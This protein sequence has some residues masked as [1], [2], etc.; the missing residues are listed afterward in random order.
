MRRSGRGGGRWLLTPRLV[1]EMTWEDRVWLPRRIKDLYK[2]LP[3]AARA[4]RAYAKHRQALGDLETYCMFI[5]YPRS[6]HSLIGSLLS[7]HP[8]MVIAHELDALHYLDFHFDRSLLFGAILARDEEFGSAHGR[9]WTGYSY[10]VEGQWQGRYRKLRVIG[11]KKGGD[12]STVLEGNQWQLDRLQAVTGLPLKVI[13]ITRN[14]YDNIATIARKHELTMDE[15]IAYYGR[16]ARS[17][18]ETT[19][20]LPPGSVLDMRLEDIV[21]DPKARIGELCAFLGVD[22]EDDYLEACAARVFPSPKKSRDAAGW[23]DATRA[24]VEALCAAVPALQ[25]YRFDD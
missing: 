22:A 18:M 12:S 13:H 6:G 21:D 11:D 19:A 10:A 4:A 7:A 5:G 8:D 25:G 14:P 3:M 17:T 16:L 23:T 15:A 2:I 9:E 24:Q 1:S 20:H